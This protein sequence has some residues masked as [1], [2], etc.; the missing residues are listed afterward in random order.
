MRKHIFFIFILGVLYNTQ[1]SAEVLS[2]APTPKSFATLTTDTFLITGSRDVADVALRGNDF[3]RWNYGR[4]IFLEAGFF[5]GLYD[6]HPGASLIRFN[7]SGLEIDEVSSAK[8]RIYKPKSMSQQ[9]PV[10]V[11]VFKVSEANGDWVEGGSASQEEPGAVTWNLKAEGKPWVGAEGCS[12]AGVDYELPALG[13]VQTVFPETS[14]WVEFNLPAA[15]VESWIE[16]PET[17][18]GLYIRGQEGAGLS[19]EAYFFSSEHLSGKGPQLIVEATPGPARTARQHWPWNPPKFMPPVDCPE[20]A[21]W[22]D[23]AS[24]R[25]QKWATGPE[26]NMSEEQGL[27]PYYWDTQ[28]RVNNLKESFMPL[29]RSLK[30][31]QEY[32]DTGD[33]QALYDEWESFVRPHLLKYED[34]KG[35]RIHQSGPVAE[36]LTNLQLGTMLG[37]EGF[38]VHGEIEK[39]TPWKTEEEIQKEIDDEIDKVYEKWEIPEDYRDTLV[40]YFQIFEGNRWYHGNRTGKYLGEVQAMLESGDNSEEMFVA[41]RQLFYHHKL[42]VHW[43][44]DFNSPKWSLWM[45]NIKGPAIEHMTKDFI[46]SR[47]DN[48]ILENYEEELVDI[49]GFYWYPPILYVDPVDESV[50]E[51]GFGTREWPFRSVEEAARYASDGTEIR[52]VGDIDENAITIYNKSLIVADG[53]NATFN[54]RPLK[55]AANAGPNLFVYPFGDSATISLVGSASTGEITSYTWSLEGETIATGEQHDIKLPVG[56]YQILL[57]ITD[58]SDAASVDTVTVTVEKAPTEFRYEAEEAMFGPGSIKTDDTINYVDLQS[59]GGVRWEVPVYDSGYYEL[60]FNVNVPGGTRSMGV[61]V[62]GSKIGKVTTSNTSFSEKSITAFLDIGNTIIELRD[63]EGTSELNVD[64]LELVYLGLD[65][66]QEPQDVIQKAQEYLRMYPNPLKEGQVLTIETGENFRSECT[67]CIFSMNG[68]K[69]YQ[70]YISGNKGQ[71]ILDDLTLEESLYILE[72]RSERS[73]IYKKLFY[74]SH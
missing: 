49:R 54:T 51:G 30:R 22:K 46:N 50:P 73:R 72:I 34:V 36:E 64:Y 18:Y 11:S 17:N 12:E 2:G 4:G 56:T 47:D 26:M 44:S 29:A 60:V 1:G 70:R 55:F 59:D 24:G 8:M 57:T 6:L 61:F 48:Y 9:N 14:G 21:E 7:V 16:N 68:R 39:Y 23:V 15:L 58:T 67:I 74:Q 37:K 62:N 41:A 71:L 31:L 28:V 63:S 35:M 45:Y 5:V 65:E 3:G 20:Y 33:E 40:K 69:V 10:E 42:Y 43:Y 38:G 27:V 25:Y 52:V 32:I 13:E 19:E 66:P 53:Y